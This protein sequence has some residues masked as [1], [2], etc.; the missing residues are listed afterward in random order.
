MISSQ[1]FKA[2]GVP[3]RKD[4]LHKVV[5]INNMPEKLLGCCENLKLTIG[6]IT[7]TINPFVRDGLNYD[8]LLGM[9]TIARFQMMCRI[10]LDGQAWIELK[11]HQGVKVQ[12]LAVKSDN[13]RNRTYLPPNYGRA[14]PKRVR[15]PSSEDS[16][17]TSY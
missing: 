14:P 11:N 7:N 6:G 4:G 16:S 12:I 8:M 1:V 3:L 13:P 17:D 9:P 15:I 2:L 10:G 5:G